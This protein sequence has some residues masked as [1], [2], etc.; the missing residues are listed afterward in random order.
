MVNAG[1]RLCCA[2]VRPV[3]IGHGNAIAPPDPHASA[4][5]PIAL[6][7]VEA[8]ASSLPM[9]RII[10]TPCLRSQTLS[11]Q[12]ALKAPQFENL[13]SRFQAAERGALISCSA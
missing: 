8:A 3:N 12:L 7:D 4:A 1:G 6:A 11:T 10:K 9:G 5:L 13:G 2:T